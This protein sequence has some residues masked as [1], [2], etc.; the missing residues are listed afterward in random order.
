M[1][2]PLWFASYLR[3]YGVRVERPLTTDERVCLVRGLLAAET[4]RRQFH[5]TTIAL[6]ALADGLKLS[7]SKRG[8]GLKSGGGH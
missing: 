5:R 4:A 2:D 3:L 7:T 1:R 8:H 6:C